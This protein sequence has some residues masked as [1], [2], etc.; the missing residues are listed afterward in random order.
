VW[1]SS[2]VISLRNTSVYNKLPKFWKQPCRQF[3]VYSEYEIIGMVFGYIQHIC[4]VRIFIS[5]Q[6]RV[7]CYCLQFYYHISA[8]CKLVWKPQ[9][10]LPDS[11]AD[12]TSVF[13]YFL[14]PPGPPG[15]KQSALRLYKSILRCSWKHLQLWRCIHDAPCRIVQVWSGWDLCTGLWETSR[16]AETSVQLSWR[17]GAVFSQQW[18]SGFHN[19]N[20]FCL[21]Y[22][23][24]L[25]HQNL[26]DPNMACSTFLRDGLYIH[27]VNLPADG[28]QA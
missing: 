23:F 24:L 10:N 7:F 21:S 17:L 11:L 22:S 28:I 13:K 6:D 18:F 19:H 14:M 12:R 27:T 20:A 1:R 8:K 4:I 15:S 5:P 25:Q 26:L 16:A 3:W 2:N 9:T